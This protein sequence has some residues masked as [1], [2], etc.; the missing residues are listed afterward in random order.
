MLTLLIV[1]IAGT[2]NVYSITLTNDT[3][4]T[5]TK[6]NIRI[7]IF[8]F[9]FVVN[10]VSFPWEKL[11]MTYGDTYYTHPDKCVQNV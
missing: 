10:Y 9:L 5:R 8:R 4:T 6:R 2:A 1:Y 11:F 7:R 3:I